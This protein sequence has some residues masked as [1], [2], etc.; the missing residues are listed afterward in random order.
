MGPGR[1][2]GPVLVRNGQSPE[3]TYIVDIST[4]M[5]RA[6]ILQAHEKGKAFLWPEYKR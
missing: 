6:L 5:L 1:R 3:G 2:T 4:A